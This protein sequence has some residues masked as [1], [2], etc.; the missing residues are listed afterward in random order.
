MLSTTDVQRMP[1]K[2]FQAV[3]LSF[4]VIGKFLRRR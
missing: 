4:R 2:I 1:N 3:L